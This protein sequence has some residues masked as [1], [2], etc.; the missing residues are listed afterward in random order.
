MDTEHIGYAV[1]LITTKITVDKIASACYNK[2]FDANQ[3]ISNKRKDAFAVES[4]DSHG[5]Y[6]Y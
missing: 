3:M 1:V 5:K 6:D 4:D 2:S